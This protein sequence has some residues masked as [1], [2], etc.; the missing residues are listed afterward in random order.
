MTYEPSTNVHKTILTEKQKE[1]IR[2][3]KGQVTQLG[4]AKRFGVTLKAVRDIQAGHL[5]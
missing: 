4:L 2:K 5:E 1:R 3:L